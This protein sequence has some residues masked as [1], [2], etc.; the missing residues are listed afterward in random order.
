MTERASES[1]LCTQAGCHHPAAAIPLGRSFSSGGKQL[2]VNSL[3]E[4]LQW[5]YDSGYFP[6]RLLLQSPTMRLV[7]AG[8][9]F[10]KSRSFYSP[11]CR[12]IATTRNSRP[13][14]PGQHGV[15]D[16][17]WLN[18]AAAAYNSTRPAHLLSLFQILKI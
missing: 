3:S 7:G 16:H 9:V 11:T 14:W 12:L 15:M 1:G 10:N 4:K 17:H 6:G 5:G 18:V 8:N 13:V 2:F